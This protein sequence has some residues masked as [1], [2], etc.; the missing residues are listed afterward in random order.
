MRW[1]HIQAPFS[2]TPAPRALHG[3]KTTAVHLLNIS[4][5]TPQGTFEIP[6]GY[7]GKK[8][9]GGGRGNHLQEYYYHD[10]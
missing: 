10:L 8:G 3:I 2:L 6:S 7:H 4:H 5:Y 1:S 9:G